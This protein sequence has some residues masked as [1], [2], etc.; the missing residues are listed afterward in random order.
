[1]KIQLQTISK[2]PFSMRLSP[3]LHRSFIKTRPKSA[4]RT[5]RS[6]SSVSRG[7]TYGCLTVFHTCGLKIPKSERVSN[8]QIRFGRN[9]EMF[10]FDRHLNFCRDCSF[11]TFGRFGTLEIFISE[12]FHKDYD[13]AKCHVN[14]SE[15]HIAFPMFWDAFFAIVHI[16]SSI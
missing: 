12:R 4:S 13:M 3:R 10:K 1:M 7:G 15:K 5:E 11:L 16:I 8:R 14:Y 9:L 6:C 2:Q